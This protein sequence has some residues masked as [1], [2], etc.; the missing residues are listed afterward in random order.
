[1]IRFTISKAGVITD[2]R[3][4]LQWAPDPGRNMN[5]NQ[6]N[7]YAQRLKLGGYDDWR[8]P[9]I[10]ELRG[11]CDP[12]LKTKYNINPLF[13]LS[14]YFLWSSELAKYG[15]ARLFNFE[16]C[17]KRTDR[18]SDSSYYRFGYRAFAVRSRSDG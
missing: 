4:G 5:W 8:L 12:S 3:T 6:A 18:R 10:S 16:S 9:T 11:L 15:E 7:S 17:Y 14:A 1:M 13:R 2:S